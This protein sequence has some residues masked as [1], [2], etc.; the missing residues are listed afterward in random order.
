MLIVT[1]ATMVIILEF[2]A[3]VQNFE[4]GANDFGLDCK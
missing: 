2:C 4:R 3:S 1:T